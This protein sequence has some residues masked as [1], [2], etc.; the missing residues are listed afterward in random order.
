MIKPSKKSWIQKIS[1]HQKHHK[2]NPR[3]LK[4]NQV[5]TSI[6][7]PIDQF[8][9][10]QR[11]QH[12]QWTTTMISGHFHQWWPLPSFLWVFISIT[13]KQSYSQ[14]QF[15]NL[16]ISNFHHDVLP[17]WATKITVA[18]TC[19]LNNSKGLQYQKIINNTRTIPS[20]SIM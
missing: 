6:F 19:N 12:I 1:E 14:I 17:N 5:C 8:S 3:Q 10:L 4:M 2:L 16:W 15:L 20:V 18:E 13:T 9:H 7:T 11:K